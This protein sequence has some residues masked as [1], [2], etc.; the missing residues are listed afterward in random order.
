MLHQKYAVH[1]LLSRDDACIIAIVR[2]LVRVGV[3]FGSL[4]VQNP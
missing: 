2:G 4:C 1:S 3:V